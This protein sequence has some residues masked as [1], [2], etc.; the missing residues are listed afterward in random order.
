MMEKGI[1]FDSERGTQVV[2]DFRDSSFRTVDCLS[3]GSLER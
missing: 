3:A 1:N 2:D